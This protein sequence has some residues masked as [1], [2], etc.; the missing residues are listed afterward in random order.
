MAILT[1]ITAGG[2]ED[3]MI[4]EKVLKNKELTQPTI[5]WHFYLFEALQKS[6]LGDQYIDNLGLWEQM[7]GAGCTTWPE[8]GLQSRS[9]CHGWGASPNYHLF[10]IMAGIRPGSPGFKTV[11][12][13][14]H[15]GKAEEIKGEF[16]HPNG[17]LKFHFTRKG[18]TG[19]DVQLEIPE[20]T[21]VLFK[22]NGSKKE[23]NGGL[24]K[25]K[26]K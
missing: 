15:P 21:E 6:G 16:P 7:I 8:T 10:K 25:L 1:D 5:Y 24:H 26:F 4:M 2:D 20:N 18:K 9:E 22:W 23:L 13:E 11:I 12:I 19:L 14:P 3:R 17:V